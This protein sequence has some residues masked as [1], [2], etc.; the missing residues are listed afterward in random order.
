MTNLCR[1]N[2]TEEL[3]DFVAKADF[4]HLPNNVR[5]H[6]KICILDWIGVALAGS[7]ELPSKIVAGIVGEMGAKKECTV[8]GTSIRT[9]CPDAALAIP[10]VANSSRI[11]I[12]RSPPFRENDLTF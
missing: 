9:A 1:L 10:I 6:A 5:K 11:S 12:I 4:E 7:S 8:I 3:A 2:I